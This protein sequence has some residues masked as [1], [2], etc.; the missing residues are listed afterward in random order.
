MRAYWVRRPR[1][2]Q[3]WRCSSRP[4]LRARRGPRSGCGGHGGLRGLGSFSGLTEVGERPRLDRRL[5]H[6]RGHE[7][8]AELLAALG[9][10]E[11]TW[12][13]QVASGRL[14]R[15]PVGGQGRVRQ[16]S[17]GARARAPARQ[18]VR[19]AAWG[20]GR[21]DRVPPD[22]FGPRRGR[23]SSAWSRRGRG[24]ASCWPP[25]TCRRRRRG[26]AVSHHPGSNTGCRCAAASWRSA[27]IWVFSAWA[28]CPLSRCACSIACWRAAI[29]RR[30]A[31]AAAA[32]A[33]CSCRST[34][35][36]IPSEGSCIATSFGRVDDYV[37]H[38]VVELTLLTSHRPRVCAT[39]STS[40]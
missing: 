16:S 6:A 24:P 12:R 1:A 23:R 33:S 37:F 30:A 15:Q 31:I 28:C 17:P 14:E 2:G 19:V 22:G 27:S 7:P 4:A 20:P 29:A 26:A 38:R 13:G 11:A 39:V 3:R 35:S 5:G 34:S 32:S 9:I 40:S 36:A 18:R 8:C 10:I 21:C 25:A